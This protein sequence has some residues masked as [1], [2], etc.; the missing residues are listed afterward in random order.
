MQKKASVVTA[1]KEEDNGPEDEDAPMASSRKK[2]EVKHMP[3]IDEF[4]MQ[5]GPMDEIFPFDQVHKENGDLDLNDEMQ[6]L[7]EKECLSLYQK[8]TKRSRKYKEWKV[9]LLRES[10]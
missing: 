1:E 6:L 2:A 8:R 10:D 4:A 7:Q 3:F 9:D 5:F